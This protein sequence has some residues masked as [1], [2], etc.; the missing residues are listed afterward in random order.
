M[1]SRRSLMALACRVASC[2]TATTRSVVKRVSFELDVGFIWP[3][4][5]TAGLIR[6]PVSCCK[7][8]FDNHEDR[9]PLSCLTR[10]QTKNPFQPLAS[11]VG[12][13]TPVFC[14]PAPEFTCGSYVD[15]SG[16]SLCPDG[17]APV[18]DGDGVSCGIGADCDDATCCEEGEFRTQR[19]LYA[20]S[21]DHDRVGLIGIVLLQTSRR[22]PLGAYGFSLSVPY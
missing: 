13:W 20:A 14:W 21:I 19:S 6:S 2:R 17:F 4:S 16:E 3:P 11:H 1:A 8:D 12:R 10:L 5:A 7:D 18:A 22:L 9:V 15:D